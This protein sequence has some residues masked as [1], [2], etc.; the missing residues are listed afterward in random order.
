MAFTE[1]TSESWFGRIGKSFGGIIVGILLFFGAIIGLWLNEQHSVKVAESLKEGEGIVVNLSE[2]VA[3]SA[4]DGKLVH[5]SGKADTSDT[6]KDPAFNLTLHALQ[7]KRKV[8]M[9]QWQENS[10][11]ESRKKLGGGTETTTTYTYEKVWSEQLLDSSDYK[12]AGHENPSSMA[13]DSE[14]FNAKPIT[15]GNFTL[16]DELISKLSADDP[17]P[18]PSPAPA[19]FTTQGNTLYRSANPSSPALGDLKITFKALM[20][21]DVSIV[22]AQQGSQLSSYQ[23]KHGAPIALLEKGTKS[24]AE[25]FASAKEANTVF[26]WILRVVGF[27]VM[28]IGCC[29]IFGP[30]GVLAD[31]LPFLGSIARFGT[32]LL[33]LLISAPVALI[34]IAI[35]WVAARPLLGISLLVI[36]V[37]IPVALLMLRKKK[38]APA[39]ATVSA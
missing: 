6:L 32:T 5:V 31:V 30:I 16:S 33:A 2:P 25:M 3:A 36:G 11:S 26:T 12:E 1:V 4:N 19:G 17:V 21:T 18:P 27:V 14:T 24:A 7:L 20:P 28:F 13:Y 15:V 39:G 23:A 37:A 29:L 8:E 38:T 34:T 9:Y 35:A 10:K 22:A